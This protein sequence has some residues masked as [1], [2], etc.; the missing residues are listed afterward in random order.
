MKNLFFTIALIL[1]IHISAQEGTEKANVFVRVYDLQGQKISKG[2]IL[3]ISDTSLQLK[4]KKEPIEV[5]AKSI[6]LIKTKHSGG[7]NVLVGAASGA[8][9]LAILG[10]AT[11]DPDAMIMGYSAG[12]GAAA[13]AFLGGTAGAAIGGI[14]TL[15]KESESYKINGDELKW[16]AFKETIMGLK[17]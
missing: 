9:L 13:G 7:N 4:G 17:Q 8:S 3:S 12:E 10:A 5:T 1:S 14:T 16:K 11:A 15:F 6:G 2:K